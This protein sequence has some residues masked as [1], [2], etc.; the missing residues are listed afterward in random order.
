[1]ARSIQLLHILRLPLLIAEF[2]TRQN[3]MG[4]NDNEVFMC[5]P[6][7]LLVGP[8][9]KSFEVRPVWRLPIVAQVIF[10]LIGI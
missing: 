9:Q 5:L 3:N 2:K 8:Q 10:L 4:A 7:A 1:M 6:D